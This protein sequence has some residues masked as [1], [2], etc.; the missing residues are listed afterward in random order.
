MPGFQE[1]P[2]NI[3]VPG[4]QD[5]PGNVQ[6]PNL[7]VS[8]L[9][10]KIQTNLQP[11]SGCHIVQNGARGRGKDVP[12][13]EQPLSSQC[14]DQHLEVLQLRVV[15]DTSSWSV[16]PVAEVV[17]QAPPAEVHHTGSNGLWPGII[18]SPRSHVVPSSVG[19]LH[20]QVHLLVDVFGS[21]YNDMDLG[22]DDMAPLEHHLASGPLSSPHPSLDVTQVAS[23]KCSVTHVTLSQAPPPP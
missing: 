22:G 4:F 11:S 2:E 16:A 13:S 12:F 10:D 18:S 3:K 17:V 14:T 20:E 5:Q 7:R 23:G 19:P 9:N 6:V 15:P 21:P 8:F 1:P